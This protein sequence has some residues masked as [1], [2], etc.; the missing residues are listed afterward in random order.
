MTEIWAGLGGAIGMLAS[1]FAA[2]RVASRRA[3]NGTGGR[4]P[5]EVR[6]AAEDRAL[7]QELIREVHDQG[8]HLDE[9]SREIATQNGFLQGRLG[10]S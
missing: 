7:I 3:Q 5:I 6:W 10:G 8:S 1:G 9:L 2:F 4:G